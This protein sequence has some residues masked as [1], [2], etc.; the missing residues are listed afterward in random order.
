M[1]N[2]I[3]LSR[4]RVASRFRVRVTT[5]I[6]LK[7]MAS[8]I[9]TYLEVSLPLPLLPGL[10]ESQNKTATLRHTESASH[11]R[12]LPSDNVLSSYP[13]FSNPRQH[14]PPSTLCQTPS[15]FPLLFTDYQAERR[16]D[17]C[18]LKTMNQRQLPRKSCRFGI[19]EIHT[20]P[21]K[22][23]LMPEPDFSSGC[24]L[25]H[26]L[27]IAA[28]SVV[29]LQTRHPILLTRKLRSSLLRTQSYRRFPH[30]ILE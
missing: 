30:L 3:S 13:F 24:F 27:L 4:F 14:L 9:E 17:L 5:C 18:V 7:R 12:L 23:K 20:N 21:R 15:P 6:E 29:F 19:V 22:Q 11:S 10:P 26:S 28:V 2:E 1:A 16:P 25:I 8:I